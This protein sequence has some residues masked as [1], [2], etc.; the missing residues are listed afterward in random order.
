MPTYTYTLLDDPLATPGGTGA[1]GINDSGQVVGTYTHLDTD[2]QHGFLYAGGT[3]TT[4]DYPGAINTNA[5]GINAS[6]QIV[7]NYNNGPFHGF[8]YSAGTYTPLDGLFPQGINAPGQI[9]GYFGDANGR[10]GFL[11]NGGKFNGPR[12]Q[13]SV[14]PRWLNNCLRHQ[15]VKPD[16]RRV[17]R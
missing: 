1:T 12:R 10:H 2:R 9:V 11:Y 5:E 4:L 13:R 3:Y 17:P 7:G 15:C 16:R 14:R 8:L 6:G